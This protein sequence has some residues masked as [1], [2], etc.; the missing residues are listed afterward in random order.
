MSDLDGNRQIIVSAP[1]YIGMQ[2]MSIINALYQSGFVD[3]T[4]QNYMASL[5]AI[6]METG[7]FTALFWYAYFQNKAAETNNGFY[8]EMLEI[9]KS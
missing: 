3:Q 1:R 9:L 2:T 4:Q 5:A 7:N 6:G 8:R